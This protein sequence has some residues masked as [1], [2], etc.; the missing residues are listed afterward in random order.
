MVKFLILELSYC[1]EQ[2]LHSMPSAHFALSSQDKQRI[3]LFV[4]P[5]VSLVY[6]TLVQSLGDVVVK[7]QE[8]LRNSLGYPHF[9]EEWSG[10]GNSRI[11]LKSPWLD[12]FTLHGKVTTEVND[13]AFE[14]HNCYQRKISRNLDVSHGKCKSKFKSLQ[15]Q[16]VQKLTKDDPDNRLLQLDCGLLGKMVPLYVVIV[17]SFFSQMWKYALPQRTS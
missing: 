14:N 1:L 10:H 16:A 3:K 13:Y 5:K 7:Q 15:I 4:E 12:C 8:N 6:H 11:L 2:S 9:R 17:L